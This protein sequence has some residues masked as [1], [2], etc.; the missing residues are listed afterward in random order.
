MLQLIKVSRPDFRN[1]GPALSMWCSEL[2]FIFALVFDDSQWSLAGEDD[3]AEA[4]SAQP[5]E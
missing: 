5:A 2:M 1:E 4:G 3:D